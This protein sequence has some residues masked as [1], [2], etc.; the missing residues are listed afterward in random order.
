MTL[1]WALTPGDVFPRGKEFVKFSEY[2]FCSEDDIVIMQLGVV[3]VVYP[4]G[5]SQ[6]SIAYCIKQRNSRTQT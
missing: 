1:A 3:M 6:R 5:Q 4:V 2:S